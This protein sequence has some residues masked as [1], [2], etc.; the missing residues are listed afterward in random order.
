MS[1]A[2]EVYLCVLYSRCSVGDGKIVLVDHRAQKLVRIYRIDERDRLAKD[3]CKYDGC[4]ININLMDNERLAEL[5][6][7]VDRNAQGFIAVGN[8]LVEIKRN[9]LYCETH[10]TFEAFCEDRWGFGK[11]QANRLIA[12]TKVVGR[13]V[14]KATPTGVA[15][16][17]PTSER[18]TRELAKVDD[19][20]QAEVWAKVVEVTDTPTAKI[21][22]SVVKQWNK[23]KEAVSPKPKKSKKPDKVSVVVEEVVE[24]KVVE[25]EPEVGDEPAEESL[26]NGGKTYKRDAPMPEHF[27]DDNNVDVPLDLY[28]AWRAKHRYS[29]LCDEPRNFDTCRRLKEIGEELGHQATIDM[30]KELR[31]DIAEFGMMFRQ[32]IGSVQPSVVI[33]GKWYSKSEVPNG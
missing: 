10:K 27:V 6:D 21:V 1:A 3:I 32:K 8:A 12:S 31:D 18:Q 9:E 11:S 20:E 14:E 30:A 5:V 4:F 17:L 23:L 22:K 2:A 28:P 16:V 26:P 15:P 19:H 29:M 7:I 33:D 24:N 13:L 25:E